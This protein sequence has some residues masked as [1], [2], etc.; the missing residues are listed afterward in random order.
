MN[1]Q[2]PVTGDQKVHQQEYS[3]SSNRRPEGTGAGIFRFQ[4]QKTRRSSSRNIQVPA[5]EDHKV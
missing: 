5:T 1:I 4:Q 2:V 3:G